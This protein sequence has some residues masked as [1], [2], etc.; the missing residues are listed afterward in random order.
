MV[1]W[2][3]KDLR[4]QRNPKLACPSSLQYL[5]GE[6]ATVI[7]EFNFVCTIILTTDHNISNRT[8]KCSF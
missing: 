2:G 6:D 8:H 1:F 4:V 3:V 7:S 5:S